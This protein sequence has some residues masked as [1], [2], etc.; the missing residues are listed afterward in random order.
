MGN[1]GLL[2]G[3]SMEKIK[4]DDFTKYKFLSGIKHSPDGKHACFVVHE[5]DLEANSYRSNLWLLEIAVERH[6]QLTTFNTEKSF[7]WLDSANILFP[8]I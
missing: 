7:V 2:G 5:S 3:L 1:L 8:N 6:F 4:I